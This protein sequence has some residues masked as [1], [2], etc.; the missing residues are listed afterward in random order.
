MPI[1]EIDIEGLASPEAV[2]EL[3]TETIVTA[4]RDQLVVLFPGIEGVIDLESEPARK[5]LEVCAY[6]E[7]LIRA[8]INDAVRANL[9]AFAGGT[10]LDQLAAFYD[11][12]RLAGE[13]DEAFRTRII[14]NI[15]GRSTGGTEPRYRAVALGADVRVAD[16][17]VWT[18]PPDPTVRVAVFSTDNDGVADQ[19]LLDAVEAAVTDPSVRMVNDIIAVQPAVFQTVD[20]T[21]DVYLLPNTPTTV[22]D[23]L[24][25]N[26]RDALAEEGGM[27]FDI[28]LSWLTARLM[29]TGVQ[30]VVITEPGSDVVLAPHQAATLG[31]ITLTNA[32]RDF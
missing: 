16:A 6:R 21:A 10:D 30:R 23:N 18:E 2:E 4:M 1:T 17:A 3:D 31:T 5:L 24:E 25:Q 29:R 32:G 12:L 26:L 13:S 28:T 20:V 22:F 7:T 14:L 15:A 8:R 11:V 9:V 19:A 27:G